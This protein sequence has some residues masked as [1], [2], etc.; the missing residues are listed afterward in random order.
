MTLFIGLG[1]YKRTGKDSFANFLIQELT[2]LDPDLLVKK[3]SFAWKLKQICYELYA[4]AGLREPEFYE[5][6]EG[7]RVREVVLPEIGKSPRQIWIDF[8]TNA[9]RDQVYEHT[10]RDYLFKAGHSENGRQPDVILVPDVRFLNEVNEFEIRNGVLIKVVRPGYGPGPN[11]PDRELLG[12]RRWTNVIG[13]VGTMASL[14]DWARQYAIWIAA[15]GVMPERSQAEIEAALAVEKIE[16]W[17]DP[18][19]K[20]I[21]LAEVACPNCKTPIQCTVHA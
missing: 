17:D 1:H 10:W 13:D 8:G 16:P 15:K 21:V 6:E 12:Y 20:P 9:V 7:A 11:R 4:W 3:L 18:S 2:D 5:T 14:Q 19:D